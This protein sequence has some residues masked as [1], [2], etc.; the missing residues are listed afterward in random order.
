L[1]DV[2]EG[3]EFDVLLPWFE[4]TDYIQSFNA[5]GMPFRLEFLL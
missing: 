5:N 1:P 2:G 4:V 3:F